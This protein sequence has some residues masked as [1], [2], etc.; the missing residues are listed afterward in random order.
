VETR[1]GFRPQLYL[2]GL[3]ERTHGMSDSTSFSMMALKSERIFQGW[4]KDRARDL[5]AD[6]V[7]LTAPPAGGQA[8][9]SPAQSE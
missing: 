4:L 1:E 3:C 6:A 7:P 5:A 8:I 9:E 2:N